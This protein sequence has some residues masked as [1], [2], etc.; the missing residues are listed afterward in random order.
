MWHRC[1]DTDATM[2]HF[3][4]VA[5]FAPLGLLSVLVAC[6]VVDPAETEQV[7]DSDAGA[8]DS[9]V[10]VDASPRDAATGDATAVVDAA[11]DAAAL[12]G[13]AAL[14]A[15][16]FDAAS[17]AAAALDAAS[18]AGAAL[19][20]AS[21]AGRDAGP[22]PPVCVPGPYAIGARKAVQVT[23]SG[24]HQCARFDDG[25]LKCWGVNA[26]GELGLGD[27]I[28]RG[29][30][31]PCLM[32]TNL[33]F[34]NLGGRRFSDVIAF[35]K[36]RPG[37]GLRT[38]AIANGEIFCWGNGVGKNPGDL[39]ALAPF[40]LPARALRFAKNHA[41]IEGGQTNACALLEGG[42]VACTGTNGVG[43]LGTG[44]RVEHSDFVV[45]DLGPGAVATDIAVND[46]S[47]CALLQAGT[48]K[49]WGDGALHGISTPRPAT[50]ATDARGDEPGEMGANLPTLPLGAATRIWGHFW[51]TCALIPNDGVRCWGDPGGTPVR[52]KEATRYVVAPGAPYAYGIF[53]RLRNTVRLRRTDGSLTAGA[54]ITLPIPPA[55]FHTRLTNETPA[56]ADPILDETGRQEMSA[57]W[58]V[59]HTY[60]VRASGLVTGN[61]GLQGRSE[62]LSG[63]VNGVADIGF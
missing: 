32:G 47:A 45:V 57:L 36:D 16:A 40:P 12:D 7:P 41:V 26:D 55:P 22:P 62:D 18:D 21:D 30:N 6:G 59:T 48:I 23:T 8:V 33:P 27:R 56:D 44:D 58:S 24:W 2:Q 39:A 5:R 53:E 29:S 25:S 20:A 31:R 60:E 49:C 1:A 9:G 46:G 63:I 54:G 34:V 28:T 13:G 37:R 14:D 52:A 15:G 35:N 42:K 38:C 51:T 61:R 43:Q 10:A 11:L 50:S 3:R 4:S 17:D 19:D